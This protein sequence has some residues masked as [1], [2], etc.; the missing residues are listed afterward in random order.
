MSSTSNAIPAIPSTSDFSIN[1]ILKDNFPHMKLQ[2]EYRKSLQL[3]KI[4]IC[5]NK[6]S[7]NVLKQSMS[8]D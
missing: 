6:L 8:N 4:L 7:Q 2:D 3:H 5:V 1:R